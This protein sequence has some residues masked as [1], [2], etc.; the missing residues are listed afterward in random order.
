LIV[1]PFVR[2][3]SCPVRVTR[4]DYTVSLHDALPIS[5]SEQ[6]RFGRS[7]AL[8]S[9][10]VGLA[11]LLT[12]G[13]FSLASHSLSPDEYGEVVLLWSVTFARKSNRLNARAW[14]I[15]YAVSCL[16]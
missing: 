8:L 3:S 15:S 10:G 11:G 16:F 6:R 13:F 1:A 12:Y 9:A 2:V 5:N 14:K 4:S 7:A